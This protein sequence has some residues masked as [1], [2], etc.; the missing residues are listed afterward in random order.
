MENR[1]LSWK[2]RYEPADVISLTQ[3]HTLLDWL[4]DSGRLIPREEDAAEIA[5]R[6]DGDI[7]LIL[8][9][10]DDNSFGNDN[11]NSEDES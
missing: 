10:G 11:N 9:E 7:D 3:D 5:A 6:D 1:A 2:Y 8:D 4:R